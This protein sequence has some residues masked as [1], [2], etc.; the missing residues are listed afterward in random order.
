MARSTFPL[1]LSLV[2]QD[3]RPA[4]VSPAPAHV[5]PSQQAGEPIGRQRRQ[6]IGPVR[7]PQNRFHLDFKPR[8][9]EER[10]FVLT[11]L[12]TLKTRGF[13]R[14]KLEGDATFATP[15]GRTGTVSGT[16]RELGQIG[17]DGVKNS[18][19]KKVK[20]FTK[21]S[22]SEHLTHKLRGYLGVKFKPI[23]VDLSTAK[24]RRASSVGIAA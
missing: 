17:F 2:L 14:M 23:G 16:D 22:S 10:D 3:L 19:G 21:K 9:S 20:A 18:K 1:A 4:P 11:A 7:D 5:Q 15:E 12:L 13:T 6:A 24:K 8:T